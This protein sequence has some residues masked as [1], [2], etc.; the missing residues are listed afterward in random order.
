[1]ALP[2]RAQLAI[3]GVAIVTL[4]VLFLVFR[5]AT[6]TSY[7]AVS[8]GIK[9]EQTGQVTK[10]LDDAKVS[11]KM[12]D[13]GTTVLV[14]SAQMSQARVALAEANVLS[15]SGSHTSCE[16]IYGKSS[17]MLS[18]TSAAQAVSAKQCMQNT[19]ANDIE[20]IDGVQS[21]NVTINTPEKELFADEA[22]KPSAAIRSTIS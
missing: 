20:G 3:G 4:L 2:R 14:P 5:A 11:Y 19:L 6:H 18:S 13:Q 10:A 16:Q 22:G 1:M 7:T 15:G 21:A 12:A 9:P 17:S 8:T